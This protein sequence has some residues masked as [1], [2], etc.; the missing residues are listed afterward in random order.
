MKTE[1]AAVPFDFFRDGGR[2]VASDDDALYVF[3]VVFCSGFCSVSFSEPGLHR[4][5]S[6]T[7]KAA[8]N[9]AALASTMAAPAGTAQT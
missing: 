9:A 8:A 1:T 3:C 2:G 6:E 5:A 7:R 4:L